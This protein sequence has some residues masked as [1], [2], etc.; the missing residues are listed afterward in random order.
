[1]KNINVMF[2]DKEF[3]EIVLKKKG[4]WHDYILKIVRGLRK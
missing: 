3:K 2:E 4:S 1:M